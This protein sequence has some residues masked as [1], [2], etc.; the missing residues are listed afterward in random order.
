VTVQDLADRGHLDGV[1]ETLADPAGHPL[2]L[3]CSPGC[4]LMGTLQAAG[5]DMPDLRRAGHDQACS[6]E[7]VTQPRSAAPPGLVGC[8]AREE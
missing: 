3:P 7:T 2:G 8:G 4:A 1:T 5:G 6:P